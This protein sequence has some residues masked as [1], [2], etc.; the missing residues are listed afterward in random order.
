MNRPLD[1]IREGHSIGPQTRNN[2]IM[3][4]NLPSDS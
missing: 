2:D 1:F 4:K 3:A